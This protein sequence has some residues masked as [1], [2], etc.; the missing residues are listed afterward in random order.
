[1]SLINQVLK[2]LEQRRE[3]PVSSAD[4]SIVTMPRY[5]VTPK[6]DSFV[7]YVFGAVLII[8]SVLVGFLVW[9]RQAH[10]SP[11]PAVNVVEIPTPVSVPAA[12]A[13][14]SARVQ[15]AAAKTNVASVASAAPS[16]PRVMKKKIRAT[17]ARVN[18]PK[19]PLKTSV[20][21]PP[22]PMPTS[23]AEARGGREAGGGSIEK[24]RLPLT[25]KQVTDQAF[26]KGYAALRKD[27]V[28]QAETFF[29]KALASTPG[30]IKSREMLAGIYIKAGRYVEAAQLLKEGVA[31]NPGHSMFR[32]L[33]ARVLLE[34]GALN[35]A[36]S[37]LE[38]DL[39]PIT[40]D[41]NYYALLAALYQRQGRHK[42]A[43]ALYQNMLKQNSM[44]GIWWIGMGISLEKLGDNKAARQAYEKARA[45]GTLATQMIQYTDNRLAALN[46]IGY[47]DE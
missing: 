3:E 23:D 4:G 2:D 21:K 18:K 38:R 44:V 45:S 7:V 29:R 22:P 10:G 8:L 26:Q 30:H 32:K 13:V 6:G 15:D 36:V 46:E 11:S 17:T 37:V 41:V 28:Q 25:Q 31:I 34:Q 20:K 42:N 12:G 43:V 47:S 19:T 16:P 35:Q 33:Y 1:M 5:V 24:Q 39:P 40:Q 14:V 27:R 9:D